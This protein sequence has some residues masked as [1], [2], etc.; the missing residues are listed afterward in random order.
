[1][2]VKTAV[3]SMICFLKFFLM[4]I[5]YKSI[6]IKSFVFIILVA[7]SLF[8]SP[9]FYLLLGTLVSGILNPLPHEHDYY[10][11]QCV[12]LPLMS[13]TQAIVLGIIYIILLMI[14]L[15][16]L[17]RRMNLSK[18]VFNIALIILFLVN[19]FSC[20]YVKFLLYTRVGQ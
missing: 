6:I 15:Y 19:I 14:G 7:S 3:A 8:V 2:L 11:C 20:N 17:L 10:I 16:Y 18:R 9:F 13:K 12:M 5:N 4:D 1:M